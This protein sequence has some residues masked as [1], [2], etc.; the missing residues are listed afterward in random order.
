MNPNRLAQDADVEENLMT[1]ATRPK[2]ADTPDPGHSA[3]APT[4]RGPDSMSPTFQTFLAT[5]TG[6]P[7]WLRAA[8]QDAYSSFSEQGFPTR[9]IESYRNSDC[10]A[11][12]QIEFMDVPEGD[13]ERVR[14]EV[15]AVRCDGARFVILNGRFEP[16]LSDPCPEGVTVTSLAAT[17]RDDPESIRAALVHSDRT[18]SVFSSLNT[19]FFADGAVV[20]IAAGAVVAAPIEIVFCWSAGAPSFASH[21]RL[22]VSVGRNAEATLLETHLDPRGEHLTN[23]AVDISVDDAARLRHLKCTEKAPRA[24][25]FTMTRAELGRDS[26]YHSVF[27]SYG[28]KLL[29]SDIYARMNGQGA[30]AALDGLYLTDGDQHVDHV[31]IVDHAVAHTTSA[32][33]YKGILG[34]NSRASF[35]GRIIVR[36]DAQ[37]IQAEQHNDNLLISEN[38]LVSSMP[39]LE[40]YADDVQCAHGS[41][42]GQL[43]ETSLFYLRSR[44]IPKASA[45]ELLAYAFANDILERIG[46]EPLRD[47]LAGRLT[48]MP[49][50]PEEAPIAVEAKA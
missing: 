40:I 19:A 14:A 43:D 47:R 13:A 33:H 11:L 15:D 25:Q 26:N 4:G 41:T 48:A 2:N 32:E 29:R 1:H 10:R 38:A 17:L 7:D 46:I 8:R 31:T 3:A 18:E 24:Y 23:V 39:Q 9:K 36:P 6:E 16:A 50:P 49:Q 12:N 22:I 5:R 35:A 20:R 45:R 34:G 42:V 21:P 27:M 44:G 28:G 30:H 37:K